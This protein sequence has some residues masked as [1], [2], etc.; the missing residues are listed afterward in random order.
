MLVPNPVWTEY[1]I[2]EV[3]G[4]FELGVM[5]YEGELVES[6]FRL[7]CNCDGLYRE[8]GMVQTSDDL[9]EASNMR[10]D[11]MKRE[12]ECVICALM[13]PVPSRYVHH[14]CFVPM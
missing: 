9:E 11:S 5:L 13:K 8:V 12:I 14:L 3:H 6:E 1:A 10:P 4:R 2:Q 7:G